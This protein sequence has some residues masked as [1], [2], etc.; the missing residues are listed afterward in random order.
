ML[1]R[2]LVQLPP[3]VGRWVAAHL[4]HHGAL[5]ALPAFLIGD[6][7]AADQAELPAALAPYAFA[8]P[9]QPG[10]LASAGGEGPEALLEVLIKL[11]EAF[12]DRPL[13]AEACEVLV[14]APFVRA[15]VACCGEE[16]TAEALG[17]V[18]G[19]VCSEE[20]PL[21]RVVDGLLHALE[22]EPEPTA[23]ARS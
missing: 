19:R 3:P 16:S 4:S 8:Q 6:S 17:R 18:L 7:A 10:C 9:Q 2:Q 1:L 20:A 14:C 15:A 23:Q 21:R 22:E 12:D 5:L 13:P 11:V